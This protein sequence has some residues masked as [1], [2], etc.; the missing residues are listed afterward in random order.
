MHHFPV[1][2]ATAL[3]HFKRFL[4]GLAVL[5]VLAIGAGSAFAAG[6]NAIVKV[7]PS[8][9]GR[10]LVDAH[11]KTLYVWAHDKS[12][13]STC[14]GACAEYWPPLLTKGRPRAIA[15]ANS[16]LLGTSR[17]ND[18][19]MQVTYAG[20]PL[21]YFALDTKAGQTKGEGLTDFG[22]RWDPVSA[23]GKAVRKG[24]SSVDTSGSGDGYGAA[25]PPLQANIISPGP[26][27]AAGAG[28]TFSVEVSLQARTAQSNSLLSAYTAAFNDPS[29]PT[30]HPGPNA[31]APGLVVL[32]STTPTAA[33]TPLQGP[34]TNLAGV[35]QINDVS[36][37]KGLTRTFNSWIV[38]KAGA[39]GKGVQATLTVYAVGGTAPALI[40]GN[41]RPISNVIRENFTIAG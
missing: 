25:A 1:G 35:F 2:T 7:G 34:N 20:H 39:F 4:M 9:L 24:G 11:G 5:T 6:G 17:R 41:E 19:R 36:Q 38:T 29:K 13:K 26:G 37:V 31:A 16:N 15:G 21:Y 33:G 22:G 27:D 30:F 8:N 14:N 28:G 12:A 23:A 3:S 40:T 32:L 10:V 18:G